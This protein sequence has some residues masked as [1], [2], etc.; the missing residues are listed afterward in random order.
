MSKLS[1]RYATILFSATLVAACTPSGDEKPPGQKPPV[2][3]SGAPAAEAGEPEPD[4]EPAATTTKITVASVQMIQDCPDTEVETPPAAA[5]ADEGQPAGDVPMKSETAETAAKRKPSPG[6]VSPGA[7]ARGG[8]GFRQPCDQSTVQLAIE[9]TSEAP[10]AIEIK[11]VR[12]MSEAKAVGTLATRKPK[13]WKNNSYETWDQ[14]VVPGAATKASYKLS[15]P[16]WSE[17]DEQIGASSFGHMFTLEIDVLVDGK[18]QTIESP[19]FPREEPHV[20][21]T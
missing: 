5:P 2:N 6:S 17:V 19:Q 14:Q 1:I 10:V 12:L 18:L 11:A 4:S 21:V 9:T 15:M 3:D 7:S 8:P 13:I 20:I 16:S